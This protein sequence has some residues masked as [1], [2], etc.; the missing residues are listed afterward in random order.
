MTQDQG[1]ERAAQMTR[2]DPEEFPHPRH[3]AGEAC[4]ARI[5]VQH[6]GS[7]SGRDGEETGRHVQREAPATQS[8]PPSSLLPQNLLAE[9]GGAKTASGDEEAALAHE[10]DDSGNTR[11]ASAGTEPVSDTFKKDVSRHMQQDP[12]RQFCEPPQVFQ[13][14]QKLA[15][16]S[17]SKPPRDEKAMSAQAVQDSGAC[18]EKEIGKQLAQPARFCQAVPYADAD[19]RRTIP[20]NEESDQDD[21]ESD[22]HAQQEPHRQS[23][24]P[25]RSFQ[26]EV[27]HVEAGDCRTASE[28]EGSAS[29]RGVEDSDTETREKLNRQPGKPYRSFQEAQ[30]VETGGGRTGSEDEGSRSARGSEDSDT[31]MREKVTLAGKHNRFSRDKQHVE[32]DSCRAASEDEESASARGDEDSDTDMREKLNRQPGQPYRSFQEAEESA[33]A[34]CSEDTDAEM[35]AKLNRQPGKPNRFSRDKHH[36]EAG[37]CR[38]ASEDE[39]SASA[40]GSEDSETEMHEKLNM[41]PGKPNRFSRDKQHVEA[42]DCRAAS[43]DENQRQPGA[44]RIQMQGCNR[45]ACNCAH[46]GLSVKKHLEM[47][48]QS[49]PEAMRIQGRRWER[50]LTG[51]R[52]QRR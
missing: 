13:E 17:G 27:Q 44:V 16:V 18:R 25:T 2:F 49:L 11:T 30:H 36:V 23:G 12:G 37:D 7:A 15:A 21:E 35:R 1:G 26:G 10:N 3:E 48:G 29:A 5:V 9:A 6:R 22:G 33:S 31:E 38:A 4:S 46:P 24:Q 47:R 20:D 42:G 43:E 52:V 39:E 14:S 50:N 19:C 45:L 28:D 51:E 32:A 40:R 34:R 8:G 41:Q